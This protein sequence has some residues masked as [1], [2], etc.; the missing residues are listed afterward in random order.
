MKYIVP[1]SINTEKIRINKKRVRN[2]GGISYKVYYHY[3]NIELIGIPYKIKK[4]DYEQYADKVILKNKNDIDSIKELNSYIKYYFPECVSL[5]DERNTIYQSR[6][7]EKKNEDLYLFFSAINT[8]K[9]YK[10]AK[11]YFIYD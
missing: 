10:K 8:Y 4:T 3:N 11:I 5:I 9:N 6:F 7:L 1:K 2:K